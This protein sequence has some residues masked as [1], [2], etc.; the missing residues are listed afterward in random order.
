MKLFE[1]TYILKHIPGLTYLLA[2]YFSRR[3]FEINLEI[4]LQGVK[5]VY[6]EPFPTIFPKRKLCIILSQ[7]ILQLKKAQIYF[8]KYCKKWSA[9]PQVRLPCIDNPN[10]TILFP[11]V[12]FHLTEHCLWN[13][14]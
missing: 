6:C 8:H 2:Y 11:F 3:N 4:L 10:W 12:K 14:K 5:P 1:Y 7:N 13:I 9:D